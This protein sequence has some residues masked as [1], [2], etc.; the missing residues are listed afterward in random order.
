MSEVSISSCTRVRLRS[1]QCDVTTR[2]RRSPASSGRTTKSW[3]ILC[4]AMAKS[5]YFALGNFGRVVL[6]AEEHV[7]DDQRGA[8]G[9][10]GVGDVERRIVVVAEAHF[11][12]VGDRAV[13]DAVGDVACG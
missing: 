3:F 1:G 6:G 7:Q 8:D 9:D 13:E 5:A 4:V 12:E 2:S 10:G 11:E